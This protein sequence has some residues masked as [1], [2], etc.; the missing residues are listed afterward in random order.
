MTTASGCS[1][2][3]S[4]SGP[5]AGSVGWRSGSAPG[6]AGAMRTGL[7]A[8]PVV[9]KRSGAARPSRPAGSWRSRSG[10]RTRR[11]WREASG[12][13]N[14][15]PQ[16]R[17]P[18]S[19]PCCAALQARSGPMNGAMS[20]VGAVACHHWREPARR[21]GR[22]Q[23]TGVPNPPELPKEFRKAGNPPFTVSSLCSNGA[24]ASSKLFRRLLRRCNSVSPLD[25]VTL[26]PGGRGI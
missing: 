10:W 11:P 21:R 25:W 22:G 23:E 5:A 18:R 1:C 3:T 7:R 26:R 19:N 9:A 16:P 14:R 4:W 2:P 15:P 12:P 24:P 17:S 20:E 13:P 8:S 6:R